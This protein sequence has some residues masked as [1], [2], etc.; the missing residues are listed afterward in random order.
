M[1]VRMSINILT[2]KILILSAN[3]IDTDRLRL[4]QEVR[5]IKEGL[6][7]VKERDQFIIDCEWAVRPRDVRRAILSFKPHIVHFSGHGAS[8]GGLAFEN[9]IGQV[10]LVQPEAL[11]GLFRLFSKRVECVL[12]NACYSEIQAN[13]IVQYIDFVVGMNTAINDHAAIEFSV[14]FYDALGNGCSVETAYEFGCNAIQLA[15]CQGYLTPVLKKKNTSSSSNG[16]ILPESDGFGEKPTGTLKTTYEFVLTGKVSEVSIPTLEAIVAHL[17]KITG[18]TSLTILEIKSGSIKLILEG[19]EEGFQLLKSLVERGELD[20]VSGIPIE[21]VKRRELRIISNNEPAEWNVQQWFRD[22]FVPE[23]TKQISGWV[24]SVIEL[25]IESNRAVPFLEWIIERT[26]LA[27]FSKKQ[28]KQQFLAIEKILKI[29]KS[30]YILRIISLTNQK[31]RFDLEAVIPGMNIPQGFQLRLINI[32]GTRW[33][34]EES[35]SIV[36]QERLAIEVLIDE[37]N[38]IIYE[39]EPEP[40]NYLYEILKF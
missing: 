17:R 28:R 11:A 5:D 10:K 32:S 38:E 21:E 23:V 4:D 33:I 24:L 2:K 6:R 37:G 26:L 31:W 12:L 13:A 39:I 30:N 19:T 1:F 35:I 40:E 27:G 36:E 9:E 20:Q 15:G 3:P 22:E 29:Q 18:D 8:G 7:L 34:E 14:G 16:N 25:Q